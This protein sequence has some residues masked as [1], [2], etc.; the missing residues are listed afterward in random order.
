MKPLFESS[1][2]FSKSMSSFLW[3]KLLK[4]QYV[5][6]FFFA[7]VY[8][9]YLIYDTL[10]TND[11]YVMF[12]SC[13]R[14]RISSNK[15]T[16]SYL[17]QFF[18]ASFVLQARMLLLWWLHLPGGLA[19]SPGMFVSLRRVCHHSHC[20]SHP[21]GAASPSLGW[22]APEDTVKYPW[23]SQVSNSGVRW[24]LALSPLYTQRWF[25]FCLL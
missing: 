14:L 5:L 22:D 2:Q 1:K 25:H 8:R 20:L 19:S 7:G 12:L 9:I 6:F 11:I 17:P 3:S 21:V 4:M 15:R 18:T 10:M 16:H 23:F 13:L 24:S